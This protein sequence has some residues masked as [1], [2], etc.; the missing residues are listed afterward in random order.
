MVN[1]LSLTVDL[2]RGELRGQAVLSDGSV[3]QTVF[4]RTSAGDI[5]GFA[6]LPELPYR[7]RPPAAGLRS[8]TSGHL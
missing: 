6:A 7:L 3:H 2:D 8:L 5:P 4:R 1:A